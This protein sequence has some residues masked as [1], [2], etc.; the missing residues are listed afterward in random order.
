MLPAHMQSRLACSMLDDPGPAFDRHMPKLQKTPELS[1]TRSHIRRTSIHIYMSIY[2][3]IYTPTPRHSHRPP[4]THPP[5][6]ASRGCSA[7]ATASAAA[8]PARPWPQTTVAWACQN[9]P[10]SLVP[11][12][13]EKNNRDA[14]SIKIGWQKSA[15][16]EGGDEMRKLEQQ[17]RRLNMQEG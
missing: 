11:F 3:Y 5:H 15:Q 12:K 16:I 2:I 9:N 13:G 17:L 8:S 14:Q 6:P 4:H 1:R 7:P 10:K